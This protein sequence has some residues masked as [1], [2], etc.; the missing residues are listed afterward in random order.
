MSGVMYDWDK[1][2]VRVRVP[3]HFTASSDVAEIDIP[4]GALARLL[5]QSNGEDLPLA[6]LP[7]RKPK[8]G[9]ERGE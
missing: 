5:Q 7:G 3:I 4:L 9:R 8:A 6:V 2:T 1:A